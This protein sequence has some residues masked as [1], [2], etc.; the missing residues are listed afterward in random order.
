MGY[1]GMGVLSEVV[2]ICYA[3]EWRRI[4]ECWCDVGVLSSCCIA[5]LISFKY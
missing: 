3:L 2:S 1:V 4:E 5:I